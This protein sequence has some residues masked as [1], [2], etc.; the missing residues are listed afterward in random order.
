[1]ERRTFL[2]NRNDRRCRCRSRFDP[3]RPGHR[4]GRDPLAHGLGLAAQ[5]P[6][7]G[8]AAQM[9]ADRIGH[10]LGRADRDRILPGRRSRAR[11]RRVRRG[12]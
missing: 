2:K 7:P 8:V 10:A 6:G 4:P 12:G 9:L 1:M 3:R 11:A 5:L